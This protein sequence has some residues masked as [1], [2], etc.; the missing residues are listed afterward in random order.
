MYKQKFGALY[1]CTLLYGLEEFL[2]GQWIFF[3]MLVYH[4][5]E[6]KLTLDP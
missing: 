1:M 5:G 3:A 4:L 2:M 6:K